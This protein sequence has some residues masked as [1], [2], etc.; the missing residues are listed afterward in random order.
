M[1]MT[2]TIEHDRVVRT[3]EGAVRPMK[4]AR[5][6]WS[7]LRDKEDTASVIRVF[8]AADGAK[9]ERN[10]ERFCATELG[11]R[12]LAERRSLGHVLCDRARLRALPEGSLGRAYLDF[13][14]REEISIEGLTAA[15]DDALS[16]RNRLEPARAQFRDRFR[17]MHDLW[18]VATGYGRDALGEI[19][20]L[21]FAYAQ[22][23]QR[24]F[25]LVAAAWS[26]REQALKWRSPVLSC[27]IEGARLGSRAAWLLGQDWEHLLAE[28][29]PAV[30]RALGIAAP[31]RYLRHVERADGATVRAPHSW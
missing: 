26:M 29:L 27:M 23:H 11:R 3:L 12:V 8:R 9:P 20:L 5:A 16:G 18:H 6:L 17:D 7:F 21:A 28:P 30:R 4:A 1:T 22:T 31:R 25:A 14:E 13:A 2:M 15:S 19:C 24:G 10:F